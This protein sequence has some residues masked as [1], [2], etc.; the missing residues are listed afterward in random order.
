MARSRYKFD[1]QEAYMA[2]AYSLRDR[3]IESWNDTQAYFKCVPALNVHIARHNPCCEG[4]FT[5]VIFVLGCAQS[6][7]E[8]TSR[9]Y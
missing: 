3:L 5:L 7:I 6:C 1:D 2:T 4:H 9:T 8:P